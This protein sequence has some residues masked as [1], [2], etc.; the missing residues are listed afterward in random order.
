MKRLDTSVAKGKCQHNVTSVSGTHF[1]SVDIVLTFALYKCN[2][3]TLLSNLGGMGARMI[4][5]NQIKFISHKYISTDILQW[6]PDNKA[7]S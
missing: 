5:S 3:M 1:S 6:I 4:K 2:V 7:Y